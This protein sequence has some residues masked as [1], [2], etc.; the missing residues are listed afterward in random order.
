MPNLPFDVADVVDNGQAETEYGM[1]PEGDYE[2]KV[3]NT[4]M[5][6]AKSGTEYLNVEFTIE[7]PTQ[8]NRKVWD[9]HFIYSD[10]AYPRVKFKQLVNACGLNSIK[11]TEELHGRTCIITVK[12]SDDGKYENVAE[13]ALNAGG[14]AKP[15]AAPSAPAP[16]WAS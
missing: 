15:A 13:Y 1:V 16:V 8:K 3:T 11:T 14:P 5:R 7:G 2:V 12:H 6:T 10:K 9:N 4:E